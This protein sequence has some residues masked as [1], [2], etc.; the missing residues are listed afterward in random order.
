MAE[1]GEGGGEAEDTAFVDSWSRV[2]SCCSTE[3]I[4]TATTF[5]RGYLILASLRRPWIPAWST[6]TFETWKTEVSWPPRGI[7]KVPVRRVGYTGSP[8]KVI[9]I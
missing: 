3:A 5:W 6:A 9:A 2:F 1:D 8:P 4:L 7:R